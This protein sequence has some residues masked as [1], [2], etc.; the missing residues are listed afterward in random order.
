[1]KYMDISFLIRLKRKVQLSV[2]LLIESK[3]GVQQLT[4]V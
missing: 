4:L 3:K 2:L 1:M